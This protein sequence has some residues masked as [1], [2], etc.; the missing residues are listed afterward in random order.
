MTE[1]VTLKRS[2]YVTAPKELFDTLGG[3]NEQ[4]SKL[5]EH[6]SGKHNQKTHGRRHSGNFTPNEEDMLVRQFGKLSDGTPEEQKIITDTLN[7]VPSDLLDSSLRI[8]VS[9]WKNLRAQY[10]N[11]E[12]GYAPNLKLIIVY[13]DT[14]KNNTE[15]YTKFAIAHEIGHHI[16]ND[17]KLS[18]F[19]SNKTLIQRIA[20]EIKKKLTDEPD[21]PEEIFASG[22]AH[23]LLNGTKFGS[24]SEFVFVDL[25]GL[26][27]SLREHLPG[28]H[29]QKTHGR[30][31]YPVTY[32][33]GDAVLHKEIQKVFDTIPTALRAEPMAVNIKSLPKNIVGSAWWSGPKDNRSF[34]INLSSKYFSPNKLE[35]TNR[36]YYVAHEI[37]HTIGVKTVDGNS[38]I[39][40]EELNHIAHAYNPKN[41][42]HESWASAVGFRIVFGD[43]F[44]LDEVSEEIFR[45]LE[46]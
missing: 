38:P 1:I 45:K 9:D 32:S 29:S 21:D 5:E 36:N 2:E 8:K 24:E 20:P 31:K 25:M 40:K 18:Y 19:D 10:S 16:A 42:V 43:K 17:K 41:V 28:K 44:R 37:A 22:F 23:K 14:F 35:L 15:E 13:R 3:I 27:E 26:K 34:E 30:R 7:M 11:N 4:R 12:A 33:G 39:T 46:I 6:L